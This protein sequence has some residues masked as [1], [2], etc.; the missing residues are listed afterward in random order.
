M[1]TQKHKRIQCY[2]SRIENKDTVCKKLIN[3]TETIKLRY[4]GKF[5]YK[6]NITLNKLNKGNNR[7]GGVMEGRTI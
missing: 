2:C 6:I 7:K 1:C 3:F 5:L 4:I